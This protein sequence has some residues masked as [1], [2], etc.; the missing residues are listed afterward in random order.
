MPLPNWTSRHG[1]S[2]A[3]HFLVEERE[4]TA[5]R[6]TFFTLRQTAI[7][8]GGYGRKHDEA[9]IALVRLLIGLMVLRARKARRAPGRSDTHVTWPESLA[10]RDGMA[11]TILEAQAP[12]PVRRICKILAIP[13]LYAA[14]CGAPAPDNAPTAVLERSADDAELISI[15]SDTFV[16]GRRPKLTLVCRAGKPAT[17]RLDLVRPPASPPPMRVFA[18]VQVKGGPEVTIELGLLERAIWEPKM[19]RPD[20][21]QFEAPDRNNQERVLPILHAFSRERALTITPPAGYGPAD[22][23]VWSPQT[24]AAHGPRLRRCTELDSAGNAAG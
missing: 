14:G 20:Q 8:R 1:L 22:K 7:R 19:P 23:L 6:P 16:D 13:L 21:P 18:Q 4:G 5:G 24:Y 12:G 10:D 3:R 11:N 9:A 17:F 15:E 2:S